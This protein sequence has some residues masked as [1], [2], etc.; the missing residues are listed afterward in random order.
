M[1]TSVS[2]GWV[3]GFCCIG[4]QFADPMVQIIVAGNLVA[5]SHAPVPAY[6]LKMIH[7]IYV[8][9]LRNDGMTVARG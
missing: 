6:D 2:I 7:L 9:P 8:P 1:N 4:G 5:I 3:N